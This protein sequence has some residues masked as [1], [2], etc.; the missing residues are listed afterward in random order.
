MVAGCGGGGGGGSPTGPGPEPVNARPTADA[1]V[2]RIAHESDTVTLVGGGT[3]PDGT[4]ASYRWEQLSG[5]TVTLNTPETA[6]TQFTAPAY[7]GGGFRLVFRLTVTDNRGASA[8]DEVAVTVNARPTADAGVDQIAQESD[9]VTLVG[10]GTDPDGTIASYRWEQVSGSS[11]TLNTPDTAT[12][13]FTAPAYAGGGSE[14]VFRLTVTDGHGASA[15]DEMIVTVSPRPSPTGQDDPYER[16]NDLEP[17]SWWRESAPYSCRQE[18]KETSPWLEAELAD[19][20]GSDPL[21]LIRYFGNGSYLR[22][23]TMGFYG[24]TPLAKYDSYHRDPPADP[25]Y[26]SLGDLDIWVDVAR[27]PTDAAG[28]H[29]DDGVRVDFSM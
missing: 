16:W 23:G 28:W 25:T 10:G 19:L 17:Q 9:T 29:L 22:Y 26:Y 15:A 3:D 4:I 21:S 6:T 24:C 13:Q 2:D 8:T 5:A 14:L 7:A 27:V 11:V 1:G 20:G 18:D 12:T